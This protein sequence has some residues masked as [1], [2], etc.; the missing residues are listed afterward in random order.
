MRRII[1]ALCCLMIIGA[2]QAETIIHKTLSNGMEVIVKENHS[3]PSV[4]VFCF[5][6]TGSDYEGKLLG[7]GVS[8]FLEHVVSG[9]STKYHTESEYQMMEKQMGAITNAY[10]TNDMTVFHMIVGQELAEQAMRNIYEHVTACSFDS[11]EV[12]REQ[13]VILKEIVMRSTP[14]YSKVWQRRSELIYNETNKRFPVIGYPELFA[15]LKRQDLVEYYNRRYTPN[16]MVLVIDGNINANEAM[17]KASELFSQFERKVLEPVLLPAQS[18]T[19]GNVELVDEF[20]IQLPNVHMVSIFPVSQYKDATAISAA[21]DLLFGKRNAPLSYKLI[22][23]E[24]LVNYITGWLEYSPKDP[25]IELSIYFEAKDPAKVKDIVATIDK[26]LKE[27]ATK[28]ITKEMLA[29][30]IN[31]IKAERLLSAPSI[32]DDCNNIGQTF[33][34]Y[35]VVDSYEQQIAQYELLTVKDVQDAIKTYFLPHDRKVFYAMPRGQ[36]EKLTEKKD[37]AQNEKP[38]KVKISDNLTVLYKSSVEKPILRGYVWLPIS[39]YYEQKSNVGVMNFV[40]GLVLTGSK[41]YDP[42]YITNWLEDHVA[43]IDVNAYGFG[44]L[45]SF[46]CLKADY[47]KLKDILYDGL[48]NPIFDEKEITLAKDG[49]KAKYEHALSNADSWQDEFFRSKI[50]AGSRDAVTREEKLAIVQSLTRQQ[51]IDYYNQVFKTNEAIVTFVGDISKQEAIQ[52]AQGI[53]DALPKGQSTFTRIPPVQQIHNNKYENTYEFEQVNVDLIYPAPKMSD[54]EYEAVT[55]INQLMNSSYGRL[56]NATRGVNDLAYFAFSSFT[57]NKDFG[58]LQLTSQTSIDKKDQLVQVMESEINR[59]KGELVSQSEINTAIEDN[60]K[61]LKSY[62]DDNEIG[63]QLSYYE[64]CG[65][66]YDYLEREA[67]LLKKVTPEQ[68]RDAANKFFTN[69]DVIISVPSSNVDKMVE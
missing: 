65:L 9:G 36:V 24:K 54:A 46:T 18:P 29:N 60:S 15:K 50:Y 32:E 44:T 52:Y 14:P 47:P 21:L 6:K 45:I 58:Y 5:V 42:M 66:G 2:L 63:F 3:S 41:Q 16:N 64:S 61:M 67:D 12:N 4:G 68:I 22:E 43:S 37:I 56:H 19:I 17:E 34:Q 38:N 35:G 59:L 33:I 11:T 26:D 39:T 30:L 8:H 23:K 51:I 1:V 62:L 28:G 31:R 40:L 57:S 27:Y 25:Q 7:C 53:Y 69:H 10:T 49:S 48:T 20:D 13:Q 55:V